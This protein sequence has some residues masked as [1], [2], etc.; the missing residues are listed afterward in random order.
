M[1]RVLIITYYW[2]PSGGSGVQ[3]WVKFSKYLPSQ[4]FQPVIYT[5]ANPDLTAID[6]TLEDD[7]PE[8][9]EIVKHHITEFYWIY[10]LLSGSK[11]KEQKEVNPIRGGKKSFMQKLML[12]ARGNLFIPDP[13]VT[14]VGTSV[15]FLKKYLQES[16]VDVI[17]S[18]GPPHSM[19]LIAMK[20]AKATSTPWVAD[21][22]DPW[23]KI[24]NFKHLPLC[25]F[26][27]RKHRRQEMAVLDNADMIVT[28]SPTIQKEFMDMTST[29]VEVITNGYDT[30]DFEQIV[31]P[32]G[33][34]NVTHTGLLVDDGNPEL[35]WKILA[36]K[37]EADKEFDKSLRIRLSGRIDMGVLRSI[38][39]VGLESK[40]VNLGYQ[41]HIVAIKEQKN[42]S[43]LILPLRNEPEKKGLLPGKLFEYMAAKK[44]VLCI[45]LS[46]GD[47]ATVLE[48]THAGKAYDW[49]DKAMADFIERCWQNFKSGDDYDQT[50]NIDKYSRKTLTARMGSL[51]KGVSEKY[52]NESK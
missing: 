7:I 39:A 17:V 1:I 8:E 31:E 26:A 30:D 5:P 12:A 6:H 45:G 44:P 50:I 19:H 20:V 9:A 37:C 38:K 41:K 29:P 40:T 16:P 43:M 32:D 18:T 10:R 4:G 33:Y 52:N 46:E 24:Y 25:S 49:N 27:K 3:R 42:A 11:A 47:T 13:R 34:F 28:V 36:D 15:R 2:P 51:L 22:R 35:L 23:T 14:W 48:E 21:F